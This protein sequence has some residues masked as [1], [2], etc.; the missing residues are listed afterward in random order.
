[1]KEILCYIE[2]SDLVS[3]NEDDPN[4]KLLEDIRT[5]IEYSMIVIKKIISIPGY[6]GDGGLSAGKEA[7]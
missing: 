7:G 6:F 1:M 2:F 5:T 3:L 4:E